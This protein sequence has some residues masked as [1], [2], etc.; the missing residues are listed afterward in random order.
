MRSQKDDVGLVID[1]GFAEEI[2][3]AFPSYRE[4]EKLG[5]AAATLG[6]D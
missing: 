5:D 2:H 1:P 4:A 6:S 3:D